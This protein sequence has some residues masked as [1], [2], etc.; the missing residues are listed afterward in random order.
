MR[1]APEMEKSMGSFV[2]YISLPIAFVLGFLLHKMLVT[3]EIG[4]ASA[5]SERILTEAKRERETLKK[6][7]LLE[8]RE[9]IAEERSRELERLRRKQSDLD[10]KEYFTIRVCLSKRKMF[11]IERFVML[12]ELKKI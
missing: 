8:G 12:K 1:P 9:K 3:K 11:L 5:E 10:K 6:E 7:A 2:L 4:G